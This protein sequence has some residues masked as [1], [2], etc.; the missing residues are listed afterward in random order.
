MT[1]ATAS[2]WDE[3]VPDVLVDKLLSYR[4][5]L[6]MSGALG[7]GDLPAIRV[8]RATHAAT[9]M[10]LGRAQL[11]GFHLLPDDH[12]AETEFEPV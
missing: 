5:E 8:A 9:E 10:H 12:L 4:H 7:P 3:H 2:D 1:I 6:L 11:V